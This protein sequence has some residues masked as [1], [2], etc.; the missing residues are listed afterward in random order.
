MIKLK[1]IYTLY[2]DIKKTLLNY[3][4]VV[5]I[6]ITTLLCFTASVYT[7]LET[8]RNYMVLD[9]I[10]DI[11]YEQRLENSAFGFKNIFSCAM[12]GYLAMFLPIIA[13]F[14]FIP[15][16][17]SERNSGLIRLTISRTGKYRYYMSKFISALIGGGLAVMLGYLIF[18]AISLCIFPLPEEYPVDP[19]LMEAGLASTPDNLKSILDCSKEL[20]GSF[21]YGAVSTVP[22]FFFASF[23]RNRYVITC[24]PFMLTYFFTTA[25]TKHAQNLLAA[26]E[27]DEAI[28]YY[29]LIPSSLVQIFGSTH[30]TLL[31]SFYGVFTLV[32]LVGFVVIMNLR[33]DKGE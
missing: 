30:K 12:S 33:T 23:I 7:D 25:L 21:I 4:F 9:V 1:F 6:V 24:L 15:N 20:V 2:Q 32:A 10:K 11:S 18:G 29:S 31:V 13:A 26:N 22:A 28:K 8:G 16:F 27:W 3:S 17:C 14:P 19:I 5:C